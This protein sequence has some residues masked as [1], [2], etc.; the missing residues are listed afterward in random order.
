MKAL[1]LDYGSGNLR[2]AQHALELAGFEVERSGDPGALR[3][4]RAIV[5][6]GQGHFRQVMRQFLDAGLGEPLLAAISAQVPVLGICVGL[7]LLLEG[8]EEAEGVSGLGVLPGRCR[9]FQGPRV[10]QMQWNT[11]EPVGNSSL[12]EGVPCAAYAYFVHSYY[13]PIETPIDD[14]AISDYGE[15]YW[16][17]VSAGALHATQFHP[18]K[19][20]AVGLQILRN[21]KKFA[22]SA[23][24]GLH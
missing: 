9:R 12:L 3:R 14:G 18:E 23:Q 13:V 6:P 24:V 21:F 8:S 16:S 22:A 7:Q 11:L 2:S 15:T 1:L 20:Q 19:S 5:V 4:A 10:P 17:L